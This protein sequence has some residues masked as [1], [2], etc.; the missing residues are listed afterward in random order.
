MLAETNPVEVPGDDVAEVGLPFVGL[1]VG[2]GAGRGHAGGIQEWR[3]ARL[4]HC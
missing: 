4:G 3:L 1:V 2:V